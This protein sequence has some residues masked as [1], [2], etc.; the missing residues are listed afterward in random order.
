MSPYR[1]QTKT[2]ERVVYRISPMMAAFIILCQIV[3]ASAG[4]LVA[5][6]TVPAPPRPKLVVR[7]ATCPP[8]TC[9]PETSAERE[10]TRELDVALCTRACDD[11]FV[12]VT[13]CSWASRGRRTCGCTCGR[14]TFDVD[15]ITEQR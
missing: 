14:A 1:E 9:P 5:R 3:G 4:M 12:A 10:A 15:S 7:S 2:T 8:P 6:V 13:E 11:N